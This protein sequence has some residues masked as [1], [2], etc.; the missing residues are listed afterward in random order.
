MELLVISQDQT[1]PAAPEAK[2]AEAELRALL[3]RIDTRNVDESER[4]FVEDTQKRFKQYGAKT[5]ISDKQLAWLRK[6]A[7]KCAAGN[8]V[9]PHLS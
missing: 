8:G 4:K 7:E 5:L 9:H 2:P 6:I 1:T 3:M